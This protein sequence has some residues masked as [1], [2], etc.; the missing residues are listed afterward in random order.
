MDNK[1]T[2]KSFDFNYLSVV[3][4]YIWAF[5][6]LMWTPKIKDPGSRL[7]PVMISIFAMVLATILLLKTYFKWGKQE[8]ISFAGGKMALLM[9]VF[10]VVYVAA[11]E[12]VGFYLATPFYL[13]LTMRVLG[14][15][16]KKLMLAISVLMSLGVFLFFDML[17]GMEIPEG[18]LLPMFLG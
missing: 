3:L 11:I 5:A 1:T 18:L 14:Q 10:L 15:K 4:I 12:V 2:K 8:E 16:N 9:A 13:Y 6:F 7:F 17:L